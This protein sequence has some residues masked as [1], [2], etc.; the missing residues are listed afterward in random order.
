LRRFL[1]RLP[2]VG[3]RFQ[4][5]PSWEAVLRSIPARDPRIRWEETGAGEGPE[6]VTLLVPR[7]QDRLGRLLNRLFEA[8]EHHRVELDEL[9][10]SVWRMCDGGATVEELIQSL[11]RRHRLQRREVEVSL[12]S[13]LRILSRRRFLVVRVRPEDLR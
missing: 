7:R 8:P 4:R 1:A 11:V 2:F 10:S 9:G 5:P 12:L 3:H 6:L 13:Y